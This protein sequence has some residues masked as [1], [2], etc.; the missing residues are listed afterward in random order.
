MPASDLFNQVYLT[1]VENF[2][3]HR[4]DLSAVLLTHQKYLWLGSDETSTIER[5]SLVDSDKFAEHQ[6]FRVAEFTSLPVSED[7]EI[8]IEGLAYTDNYLWFVGSHSYK[9]KKPKPDKTD[10]QNFKR[11]TK[12]ESEPNRY[13]LGRIPLIDGNLYSSCPNPQKLDVQLNAAKL[14][15]TE[16]GN[17]LMTALAND[18]HLGLFIK[19]SIPGKDNGFDIEGIGVYQNRI[20]LGLRGPVLRGWAIVLEIELE[21]SSPGILKLRQIGEAKELYKKHFVWLN[22]L[23]IRDLYT[24]GKDLLILAGPT[25]DLDGPVQVYRWINGVNLRENVFSNPDFVQDIPYGNREEHAEGMT[26]FQDVA[27]IP[28]LLVVYDSPAQTRLVGDSTV[29]ADV[30]KLR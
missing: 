7:Q 22:G 16:Q 14:E 8:D 17:L 5:L 23:G 25:M 26:L 21:D 28:S 1:F 11:L 19:A 24:D 20:F 10:A 18:P 4:K 29:I 6:Q 30:F 9:R 2:K 3:E 27:G 12:I 13:I 15:V